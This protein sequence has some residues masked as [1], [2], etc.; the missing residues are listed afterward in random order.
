MPFLLKT[1]NALD[2]YNTSKQESNHTKMFLWVWKTKRMKHYMH[3][4]NQRLLTTISSLWWHQLSWEGHE[5]KKNKEK[6]PWS[7]TDKTE[8]SSK[9]FTHWNLDSL[10]ILARQ[11]D[12]HILDYNNPRL[13]WK[14]F[15]TNKVICIL[16]LLSN[17]VIT[18]THFL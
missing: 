18:Q 14:L 10:K 1:D 11:D 6:G 3:M 15:L 7:H 5:R 4:S 13:L 16:W 17:L 2:Q 9:V 12:L 8:T